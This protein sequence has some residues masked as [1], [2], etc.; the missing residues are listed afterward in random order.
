MNPMRPVAALLVLSACGGGITELD[1]PEA[2][3]VVYE[4]A[5]VTTTEDAILVDGTAQVQF[6]T[7]PRGYFVQHS[8]RYENGGPF[9][10]PNDHRFHEGWYMDVARRIV[11]GQTGD[12][13]FFR[14]LDLGDVAF[15]GAPARKI[16]IDTTRVFDWG[17]GEVRVYENLLLNRISFYG[18]RITTDGRT[19]TF[20]HEP[21]YESMLAGAAIE[22]TGSGS[23]DVEPFTSDITLRPG[24]R[25]AGLS[26]GGPL[27]FQNEQ[28]TLRSDRN[29]V[30]DFSRP[31]DR[32]RTVVHIVYLDAP[33]ADQ[34]LQRR[35]S[36]AFQLMRSTDRVVIP[37]PALQRIKS[38]V[39]DVDGPFLLRV[40]EH[41][42][43]DDELRIERLPS[44]PNEA[45]SG[46][47]S[48]VLDLYFKM[49]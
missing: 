38:E 6:G 2:N 44:G 19:V 7:A 45:L 48:N 16:A 20:A 5:E 21:F 23:M 35:A 1:D 28:P 12:T 14:Y 27:D 49:R 24:A 42:P 37:H 33:P 10:P 36:A 22:L 26:S 8:I 40:Y 46:R 32:E 29:L 39:P 25:L 34:E 43:L 30:I 3:V 41:V 47:Q 11:T 13:V 31:L 9:E 18:E 17:E 4:A 15:G